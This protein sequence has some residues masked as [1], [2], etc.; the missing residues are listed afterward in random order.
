MHGWDLD[1]YAHRARAFGWHAIEIE[2]H[3]VEARVVP[4]ENLRGS[5]A[6]RREVDRSDDAHADAVS[7][8]VTFEVINVVRRVASAL[9]LERR[10]LHEQPPERASNHRAQ[11]LTRDGVGIEAAHAKL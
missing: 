7:V 3:D 11:I 10:A 1:S 6:A 4:I 5:L 8:A 2:G 9:H